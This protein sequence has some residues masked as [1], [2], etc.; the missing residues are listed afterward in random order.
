MALPLQGLLRRL[1]GAF[2]T[3]PQPRVSFVP[4]R[5]STATR[6]TTPLTNERGTL[7]DLKS[8]G[9]FLFTQGEIKPRKLFQTSEE[10]AA[11]KPLTGPRIYTGTVAAANAFAR[12]FIEMPFRFAATVAGETIQTLKKSKALIEDKPLPESLDLG[13]NLKRFG[14]DEKKYLDAGS[15]IKKKIQKGESPL[16]ATVGVFSDKLLDLAFGAQ[17]VKQFADV[18]YRVLG[19]GGNLAKVEAWQLLGKPAT[20]E[21]GKLRYLSQAQKLHPDKPGGSEEA[22]KALG[23]AWDTFQKEGVPSAT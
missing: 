10:T 4:T 20:E 17:V 9:K 2:P 5:F 3:P 13:V 1:G 8:L 15:E 18:S 22:M 21:A 11:E 6:T 16:A 12:T 19:S 23:K 14:Y 7:D